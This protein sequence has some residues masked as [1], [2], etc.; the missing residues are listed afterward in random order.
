MPVPSLLSGAFFIFRCIVAVHGPFVAWDLRA[1]LV[2]V[3]QCSRGLVRR[4]RKC[5]GVVTCL[6]LFGIFRVLKWMDREVSAGT[7]DPKIEHFELCDCC[8][9]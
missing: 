1:F 2:L 7:V 9:D 4:K 3:W 6:L 8:W 5:I